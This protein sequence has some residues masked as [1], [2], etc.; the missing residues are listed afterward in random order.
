MHSLTQNY[1]RLASGVLIG[2]PEAF[3]RR[4]SKSSMQNECLIAGIRQ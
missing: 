2:L 1:A 4:K 3:E